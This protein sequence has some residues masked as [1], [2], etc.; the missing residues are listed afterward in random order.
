MTP[1]RWI[2]SVSWA[3]LAESAA[4]W[5]AGTIYPDD[6]R[7]CA[8][9]LRDISR[10][11][12]CAACLESVEAW[13]PGVACVQCRAPFLEEWS[14]DASGLC[15][16]CR[17]GQTGFDSAFSYGSYQGVLRQLIHEFK[18][19]RIETLA[20]PLGIL[21]SKAL[22]RDKRF[23]AIVPMPMHWWRRYRRGFNQAA[24]LAGELSRR[25]GIPVEMPL[26]REYGIRQ[27]GLSLAERERNRGGAFVG[28]RGRRVEG[29]RILLIDDVLTTGA[30][31]R[32]CSRALK[33]VGAAHVSVVTLARADR[34]VPPAKTG[35]S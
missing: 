20:G 30:T 6:C 31:A 1:R 4:G 13:N 5:V 27:S 28:R 11:P 33:R 25:T 34:R 15:A 32:A 16:A 19:G 24:L 29:K 12:V 18:Y 22:P 10:V 3:S 2:F 26:R 35:A 8:E 14:L 7:I 17:E 9:P 21:L 23:D